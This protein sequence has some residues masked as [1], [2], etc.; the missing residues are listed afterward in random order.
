M[1]KKP[2]HIGFSYSNRLIVR[3]AAVGVLLFAGTKVEASCGDY[4]VIG[5]ARNHVDSMMAKQQIQSQPGQS[6]PDHLP[7]H[8]SGPNCKSNPSRPPTTP[9]TTTVSLGK[10]CATLFTSL[11]LPKSGMDGVVPDTTPRCPVQ[12]FSPPDPPPRSSL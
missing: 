3:L 1:V 11:L 6:M 12:T 2:N 5:D 7:R 10:P 4:L 8:C 9:V